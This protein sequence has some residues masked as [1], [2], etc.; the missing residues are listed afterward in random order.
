MSVAGTKKPVIDSVFVTLISVK[1]DSLTFKLKPNKKGEVFLIAL[2]SGQFT[3]VIR[4]RNYL[5]ATAIVNIKERRVSILN[6]VLIPKKGVKLKIL[7]DTI[8]KTKK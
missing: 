6:T 7:N 1:N 2:P 3:S 5:S 8:P 4:S